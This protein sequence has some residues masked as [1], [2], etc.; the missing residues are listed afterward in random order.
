MFIIN[1]G[2][3]TANVGDASNI[4]GAKSTITVKGAASVSASTGNIVNVITSGAATFITDGESLSGNLICDNTSSIAATLQNNSTLTGSID[5]ASLTIDSTSKWNVNAVSWL[6]T[7][8]DPSGISGSSMTNIY[9]NGYN[10]YYNK[11]LS[12]NSYLGG[13][14][15]SLV[16]GGKL[17]PIGTTGVED[18]TTST[19]KS[20][21][22]EQNYPN[23]FNPT[24]TIKFSVAQ[25]RN[26]QLVV[27][28]VNGR[29]IAELLNGEK[30]PSDYEI[31]F[32]ESKLSSG[33]YFYELRSAGFFQSKK[34]IIMK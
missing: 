25:K 18:Q 10:V 15:Y 19:P 7:L 9:G 14:T 3:I 13:L 21:K 24:T 6:K 34:M 29:K 22:L 26:V 28:E 2:S 31:I 17:L 5:S 32:N 33:V 20:F 27:Y 8:I 12:A 16:N 11:L 23:P 1:G 4:N 30:E